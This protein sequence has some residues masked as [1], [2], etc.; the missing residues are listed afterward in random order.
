MR[1]FFYLVIKSYDTYHG[2]QEQ[3]FDSDLYEYLLLYIFI[4]TVIEEVL[5]VWRICCGSRR[6]FCIKVKIFKVIIKVYIILYL[7]FVFFFSFFQRLSNHYKPWYKVVGNT[8][9]L[10]WS[11]CYIYFKRQDALTI[12]LG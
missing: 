10:Y 4:S 6:C 7:K 9:T 8:I 3:F 1:I 11:G 12:Y 5:H 2:F